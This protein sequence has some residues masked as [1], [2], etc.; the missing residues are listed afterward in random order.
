MCTP[1]LKFQ[2][3]NILSFASCRHATG[4]DTLVDRIRCLITC[5]SNSVEYYLKIAWSPP[6]LKHRNRRIHTRSRQ[7][8]IVASL[9][10]SY[11][12]RNRVGEVHRGIDVDTLRVKECEHRTSSKQGP[13][14]VRR[15][16][17]NLQIHQLWREKYPEI[18]NRSLRLSWL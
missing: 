15:F 11:D 2:V 13:T 8:D 16:V 7:V 5:R 12:R 3:H 9:T 17:Y 14:I 18:E 1:T 10:C 4:R 6:N